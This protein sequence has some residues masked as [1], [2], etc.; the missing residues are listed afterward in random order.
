MSWPPAYS[1]A[2]IADGVNTVKWG[3][4]GIMA[5]TAPNGNGS[6]GSFG[7]YTLVSVD[8][9]DVIE[10]IYIE[11]GTGFRS[12]RIKLWQGREVA[13]TVI[14]DTNM[15]PP[16]PNR[17]IQIIDPLSSNLLTFSVVENNY[18]AARKVEGQR[19]IRAVYDTMIEGGG[20]PPPVS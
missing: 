13:I 8:P 2:F 6:G 12:T 5:N 4:D 7:F 3:T 1:A 9:T 19:V 20:S 10:T 14:D 17:T 16:A 18:R 11:Q 15:T